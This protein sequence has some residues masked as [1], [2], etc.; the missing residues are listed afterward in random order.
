MRLEGAEELN[1]FFGRGERGAK[2]FGANVGKALGDTAKQIAGFGLSAAKSLASLATGNIGI[3]Q[4]AKNVLDFRDSLSD[5]AVQAGMS[6][7]ELGGLRDQIHNVAKASNQMQTDVVSSLEAFVKKTGDIETARKNLELYAKVATATG[8]T[9]SD[10]TNIGVELADKMGL[11]TVAQQRQALGILS[12]QGRAGAVEI[13]D[14]ATKAPAIFSA[15]HSMFGVEG[16]EGIKGTGALAQVFAK[17]FGG[18]GSAANISTSIQNVFKDMMVHKDAIQKAGIKVDGRD[19]Y[20]VLKDIIVKAKGSPDE[21]LRAGGHGIFDVRAMRGVM[22][23]ASEFKKTGGF[24]T[25][26]K[27]K[28]AQGI[29]IDSDV[30]R[31]M[32][33]G[34]SKTKAVQIGIAASADKN[35]GDKFDYLA[36]KAEHLGKIFDYATSHLAISAAAAAASLVTFKAG[37]ALAGQAWSSIFGGGK[38]GGGGLLGALGGRGVQHVWVDNMGGGMGG[39]GTGPGGKGWKG[40]AGTMAAIGAVIGGEIALDALVNHERGIVTKE[41]NKRLRSAEMEGSIASIMAARHGAGLPAAPDVKNNITVV[42][43]G[44]KATVSEDGGTRSTEA[45]VRRG[46]EAE[47]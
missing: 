25:F 15:A 46:V 41:S 26:D 6:D 42:I 35:L 9:L 38:G 2:S 43:K 16:I 13:R 7:G 4:T 44:D 17:A 40:A 36:G 29:D 31:R 1:Q 23:M 30:A 8:A 34:A 14:L 24:E 21:L 45:L 19:P 47:D 10:V 12:Q 27:F 22:V 37:S 5:L 18:T 28:N 33:T 11:K 39:P 3:A 32:A 20:E